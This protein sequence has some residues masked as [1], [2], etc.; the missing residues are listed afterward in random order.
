MRV[1]SLH[2]RRL[3]YQ[4]IIGDESISPTSFSGGQASQMNCIA[5]FH[6]RFEHLWTGLMS[7]TIFVVR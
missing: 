6:H 5:A 1:P 4:F 3:A 2:C 7:A